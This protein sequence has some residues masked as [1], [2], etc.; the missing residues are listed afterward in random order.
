M[1]DFVEKQCNN[2]FSFNISKYFSETLAFHQQYH[3][4][5]FMSCTQC[6]EWFTHFKLGKSLI[7]KDPRSGQH[8]M[9]T[10]DGKI[11]AVRSMIS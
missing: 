4:E 6:Y 11:D 2:K 10:N 7:N 9:S 8:S 5:E 3:K 1:K